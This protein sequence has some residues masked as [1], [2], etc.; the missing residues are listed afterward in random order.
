VGKEKVKDNIIYNIM[1]EFEMKDNLYE[2]E[3]MIAQ[4]LEAI[5][6]KLV[7]DQVKE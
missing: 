4:A 5:L 3:K 1:I 6:D 2:V 7:L